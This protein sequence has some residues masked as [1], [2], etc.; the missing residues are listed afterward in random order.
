VAADLRRRL[1]AVLLELPVTIIQWADLTSLEP[2]RDAVEMESVIADS[3]SHCAFFAGGRGLVRLAL[4]AEVHDMVS[5]NGAVVDNNVP[6]PQGDGVP[7][8]HLEAGLL[9]VVGGGLGRL[10]LCCWCRRVGHGYI[11]HYEVELLCVGCVELGC[12]LYE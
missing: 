9:A 6:C 3:P 1:S 12:E 8:L 5:A 11:G 4:D 10:D 2:S 7:F